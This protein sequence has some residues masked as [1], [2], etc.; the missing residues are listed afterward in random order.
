MR[1]S[2]SLSR[3]VWRA[4]VVVIMFH[5]DF[6]L[7]NHCLM[8]VQLARASEGRAG[9]LSGGK[10]E[11]VILGKATCMHSRTS[12][13][14]CYTR[15]TTTKREERIGFISKAKFFWRSL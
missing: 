5:F 3:R 7:I 14:D 4:D 9:S 8:F 6:T 13:T 12:W 1:R 11:E 2:S 10:V 15:P